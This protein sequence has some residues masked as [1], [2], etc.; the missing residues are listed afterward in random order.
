MGERSNS[1]KKMKNPK[2][3]TNYSPTYAF[4]HH[5]MVQQQVKLSLI[6]TPMITKLLYKLYIGDGDANYDFLLIFFIRK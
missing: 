6:F 2:S 4:G 3:I 1:K 5:N